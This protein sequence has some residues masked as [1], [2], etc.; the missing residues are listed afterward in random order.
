[1]FSST[2]TGKVDSL[3]DGPVN[4]M[5]IKDDKAQHRCVGG[6]L[7]DKRRAVVCGTDT[8]PVLE[9]DREFTALYSGIGA[10]LT[11]N[12]SVL[13]LLTGDED[14]TALRKNSPH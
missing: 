9:R 5:S 4:A 2:L 6:G 8:P 12:E 3:N 14:L 11:Q 7:P 10:V 1:M 13:P